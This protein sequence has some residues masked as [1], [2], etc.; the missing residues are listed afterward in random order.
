MGNNKGTLAVTGSPHLTACAG[1]LSCHP[2]AYLLTEESSLPWAEYHPH[3]SDS[4]CMIN[5]AS[6]CGGSN[7]PFFRCRKGPLGVERVFQRSLQDP[8]QLVSS[9]VVVKNAFLQFFVY[10]GC[11]VFTHVLYMAYRYSD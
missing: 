6:T 2:V 3:L 5:S 1:I 9:P 11:K 7:S 10:L 4:A 8:G